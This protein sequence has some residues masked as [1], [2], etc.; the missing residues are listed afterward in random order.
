MGLD[1]SD[2]HMF[3]R[4]LSA[5]ASKLDELVGV[6][7]A[8]APLSREG[9]APVVPCDQASLERAARAVHEV[10]GGGAPFGSPKSKTKVSA[11][12]LV[13][14]VVRALGATE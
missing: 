14:T 2:Y 7:S 1:E 6:F 5:I 11:A 9:H 12:L 13:E 8:S 4:K 3:E 10:T